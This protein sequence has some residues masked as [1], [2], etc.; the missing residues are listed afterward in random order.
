MVPNLTKRIENIIRHSDDENEILYLLNQLIAE[1]D[2]KPKKLK[3]SKTISELFIENN[4][5]IMNP[6]TTP[7]IIKTGFYSLDKLLGGFML[8]DFIVFGG[9]PVMGLT[10]LFVNLAINISRTIPTLFVSL[11]LNEFRLT[12]RIISLLTGVGLQDIVQMTFNE[13]EKE[14]INSAKGEIDKL[15]LL[16][17]DEHAS[18]LLDFKTL[19]LKHIEDHDVKV[20]IVDELQLLNPAF[21][22]RN[23]REMEI[24]S[25]CKMLKSIAKEFNVCVIAGSQLNRGVEGRSGLEGKRPQLSDL[26]ESGAIEQDADKIIF[27]HRP[28][29][30]HLTEDAQGNSLIGIMELIIAKNRIGPLG[31]VILRKNDLFTTSFDKKYDEN[32]EFFFSEKRLNETKEPP[33]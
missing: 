26:R 14:L 2:I 17:N 4:E 1:Q 31:D 20:I 21:R 6:D 15:N 24:S 5:V 28:E 19:C 12:S 16:V 9:R 18:S 13:H 32:D 10:Q 7:K 27:I 25:I 3:E 11:D 29:Y 22:Y 8:G 23:S 30:Y 33:Y